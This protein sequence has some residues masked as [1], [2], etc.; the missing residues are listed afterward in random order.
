MWLQK[1]RREVQK[2]KDI[3]C[4]GFTKDQQLKLKKFC[5]VKTQHWNIHFVGE[6]VV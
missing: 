6:R 5:N 2:R 1:E 3:S 4:N